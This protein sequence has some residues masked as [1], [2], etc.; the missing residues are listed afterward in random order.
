MSKGIIA[1]FFGVCAVLTLVY[2]MSRPE[3]T[4]TERLED[5][6]S[7]AESALK[8]AGEAISES[9]ADVRAGLEADFKTATAELSE[10]VAASAETM[11]A[12]ATKLIAAW[13][14][15]AIVTEDGFDFE[16]AIKAVE[17]SSLDGEKKDRIITLLHDIRD[18]P[19]MAAEKLREIRAELEAG[20]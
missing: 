11:S 1:A 8:D 13:Q 2:Y 6:I 7:D 4:P 20:N 9:V 5:A 14:D 17:N 18:A 19:E 12:E 16:N 15:A 10:M 3:P